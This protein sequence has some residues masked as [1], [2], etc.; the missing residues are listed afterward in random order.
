MKMFSLLSKKT[1]VLLLATSTLVLLFA[2]APVGR[3]ASQSNEMWQN[4]EERSLND[5]GQ[6]LIV[7]SAY[8]TVRLNQAALK[9]ALAKAPME[10]TL[11]AT[12][13][14]AIIDLPMPDG[15]LARFR[16]EESP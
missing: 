6:R 9:A 2:A 1:K 11:E 16:F 12:Q 14:P 8:R 3:S 4:I 7:P 13:H 5:A 10:F 15:T